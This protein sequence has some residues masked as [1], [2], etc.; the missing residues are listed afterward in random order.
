MRLSIP[1]EA[2][3]STSGGV[4]Q[5]LRNVIGGNGMKIAGENRISVCARTLDRRDLSSKERKK[6]R[7]ASRL[8][9]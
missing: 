7:K 8:F 2:E 6:R 9:H 3:L 5:N 4:K 1:T